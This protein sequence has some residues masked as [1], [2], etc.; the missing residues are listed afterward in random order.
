MKKQSLEFFLDGF[1]NL[2]HRWRI[3]CGEWRLLCGEGRAGD[4]RAHF[5]NF[6]SYFIYQNIRIRTKVEMK[7]LLFIH[8]TYETLL[9][10]HEQNRFMFRCTSHV[11]CNS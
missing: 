3:V 4:K 1:I 9:Y 10:T 2:V 6:F 11:C 8:P 5:K 7:A